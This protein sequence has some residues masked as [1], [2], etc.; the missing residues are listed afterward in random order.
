MS[1]RSL[2]C[3]LKHQ[4]LTV[5]ISI[6]EENYDEEISD[7]VLGNVDPR[8]YAQEAADILENISAEEDEYGAAK[9]AEGNELSPEEFTRLAYR[10]YCFLKFLNDREERSDGSYGD[11][12]HQS[13]TFLTKEHNKALQ[14]CQKQTGSVELRRFGAVYRIH[15]VLPEFLLQ[16][17]QRKVF[18]V[19]CTDVMADVPRA[20]PVEKIQVMLKRLKMLTHE[21]DH[22]HDLILEENTRFL[23]NYTD[24]LQVCSPTPALH[25]LS[26]ALTTC[27]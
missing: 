20:N 5:F 25:K 4:I 12:V 8:E 18:Q 17:Q 27:E 6:L 10:N 3:L 15:F 2:K 11:G 9:E 7:H 26:L 23:V 14:K 16:I 1:L 22:M 19:H 13:L 24:W 21:M